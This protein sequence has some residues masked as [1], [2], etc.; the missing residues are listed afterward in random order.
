MKKVILIIVGSIA[1][2]LGALGVIMPGLPTTPFMLL[3]MFCYTHSSEKLTKKL[4]SS[5]FYK[6]FLKKYEGRKGMTIREKA[7]ISLFA[8]F[9]ATLSI[10][11]VLNWTFTIIIASAIL[12][13]NLVFIFVIKTHRE[14]G[15]ETKKKG[16]TLMEKISIFV[17]TIVAS[18]VSTLNFRNLVF[19]IVMACVVLLQVILFVFVIK[20]NDEDIE[21]TSNSK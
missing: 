9:M 7:S 12:V 15:V 4:A 10:L 19:T 6:R 2:F 21:E 1:F 8:A 17:M 5:R 14:E 16:M 11:T 20:T 3:A 13:Q 18:I